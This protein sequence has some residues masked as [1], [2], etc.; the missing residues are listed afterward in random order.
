MAQNNNIHFL[1]SVTVVPVW[2]QS[3]SGWAGVILKLLHSSLHLGC[4]SPTAGGPWTL[5]SL[6]LWEDPPRADL[7]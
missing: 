5:L 1:C 4:S 3:G 2:L 7:W 6:P